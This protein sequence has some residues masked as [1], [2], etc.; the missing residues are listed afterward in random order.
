MK[1]KLQTNFISNKRW[2]AAILMFAFASFNLQAQNRWTLEQCIRT[3]LANNIDLKVAT[4]QTQSNALTVEQAKYTFLPTANAD[5]SHSISFG[6]SIDPT[7][8]TYK[9]IKEIQSSSYSINSRFTVFS[10]FQIRNQYESSKLELQASLKDIE[11]GGNDLVL[12]ITNAYLNVLFNKEQLKIV[13]NQKQISEQQK[14]QTERLI[15]AGTIAEIAIKDI[16]AQLANDELNIVTAQNNYDLALLKLKQLIQVPLINNFELDTLNYNAALNLEVMPNAH[17]LYNNA[18]YVQPR[19]LAGQL[20]VSV[21]NKNA[22]LKKGALYPSLYLTGGLRSNYSSNAKEVVSVLPTV[23]KII[24]YDKQLDQ[25]F[26]QSLGLSLNVPIFNAKSARINYYKSNLAILNAQ[27]N[28]EKNQLQLQNDISTAI[29]N[30]KAAKQKLLAT[31][32]YRA[33]METAFDATTKKFN[34]GL[35]NL[36]ELNTSKNNLAKA[37]IDEIN[38]KY[39]YIF[40]IKIIDF[41]QGKQLY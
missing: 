3:G 10:G 27:Y 38:A 19:I 40:K 25:N 14:A 37:Q 8:N 18:L 21:A 4:L 13:Q 33:A 41:Y 30:V 35:I 23:T 20:R 29:A 5:A 28:L 12:N 9:T 16:E 15:K 24:P 36:Y 39:D 34:A 2:Y 32:T 17:D 22:A 11:A 31:G 6:R 7:T 1:N 26:G